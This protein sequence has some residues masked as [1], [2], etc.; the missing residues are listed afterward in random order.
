MWQQVLKWLLKAL[1]PVLVEYLR[2]WFAH[3]LDWIWER[4]RQ[5]INQRNKREDEKIS[6]MRDKATINASTAKSEYER[7]Y[8]EGQAAALNDVLR[9][10]NQE[11][12][13]MKLQLQET[14]TEMQRQATNPATIKQD[15]K[16]ALEHIK[17]PPLE[18]P[19]P[20]T[21]S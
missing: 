17:M 15:L 1:L 12:A 7:G 9:Q 14:I 11:F 8:Y 18:L 6:E 2:E 3:S 10:I 19:P 4:L 13:G 16:K 21:P 5:W 20:T